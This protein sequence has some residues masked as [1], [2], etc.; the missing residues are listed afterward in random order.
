MKLSLLLTYEKLAD[1]DKS[2]KL[3]NYMEQ[4]SVK[5]DID[6]IEPVELNS[7]QQLIVKS[8]VKAGISNPFD[9]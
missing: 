1:H 2:Y 6:L 3:K 9:G 8:K 4:L 5:F 7:N